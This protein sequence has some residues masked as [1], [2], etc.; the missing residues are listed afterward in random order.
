MPPED[1]LKSWILIYY[2]EDRKLDFATFWKETGNRTSRG[3]KPLTKADSSVKKA[4]EEITAEAKTPDEKLKLLDRFCRTQIKNV[5]SRAQRPDHRTEE[6]SE[7]QPQPFRYSQAEGGD[8]HG[9]LAPVYI[10]LAQA[11]RIRCAPPKA[12]PNLQQKAFHEFQQEYNYE[13]PH[14]A[15]DD[16]T[17]GSCYEPSA[18]CYPR[19]I[20]ELEYGDAMEV[21]RV[22]QQGSL[23]W[24]GER[25]Y[26][27]SVFSYEI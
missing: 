1:E 22:S 14:E 7:R 13:R 26:I 20:P 4:A 17:P 15:L 12:T 6:G 5:W 2:E 25:T 11:G 3:T 27:S 23:K 8:R 10:A 19:R 16:R 21:R 24:N 18:R 9:Y